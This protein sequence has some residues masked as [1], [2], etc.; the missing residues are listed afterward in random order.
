[1][2]IV[3]LLSLTRCQCIP[4]SVPSSI[5]WMNARYEV[6]TVGREMCITYNEVFIVIHQGLKIS[7][8]FRQD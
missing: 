4:A 2:E 6:T 1:M 5:S 8:L 3:S 7:R